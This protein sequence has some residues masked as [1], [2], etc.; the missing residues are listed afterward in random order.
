[1]TEYDIHLLLTYKQCLQQQQCAM[2]CHRW[3]RFCF[4][5]I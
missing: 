2:L 4:T 1:M 3:K 5:V